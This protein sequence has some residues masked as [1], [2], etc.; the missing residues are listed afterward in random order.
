[1][2]PSA[3]LILQSSR[4]QCGVVPYLAL[5]TNVGSLRMTTSK[6]LLADILTGIEGGLKDDSDLETMT[7]QCLFQIERYDYKNT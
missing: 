7:K 6:N 2:V 3:I 5:C 1:M 4:W